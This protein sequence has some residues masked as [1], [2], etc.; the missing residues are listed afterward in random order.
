M[1]GLRLKAQE[2]DTERILPPPHL[3][4]WFPTIVALIICFGYILCGRGFAGLHIPSVPIYIGEV[5][6]IISFIYFFGDFFKY[7]VNRFQALQLLVF[8]GFVFLLVK[9]L[10]NEHHETISMLR[11]S[12][13]FYYMLF[14]FLFSNYRG[15]LVFAKIVE[16][17]SKY[18]LLFGLSLFAHALF[19]PFFSYFLVLGDDFYGLFFMPGCMVPPL[20]TLIIV[21]LTEKATSRKLTLMELFNIGILFSA[22]IMTQSRGAILGAL[23]ALGVYIVFLSKF[24]V[25]FLS[26]LLLGTFF[27]VVPIYFSLPTLHDFQERLFV[28]YERNVFDFLHSEDMLKAKFR[29]L[30]DPKGDEY[31]GATGEGRI[32]WWKAVI[33]DNKSSPETFLLGQGFG[34]NL[35][36]A[37]NYGKHTVRGAHNA[38]INIFGWTGLVGV[39]LYAIF[40]LTVFRFFF[41]ARRQLDANDHPDKI[42]ACNTAL[43]FLTAVLVTTMFDNS[44]SGPAMVIPLY[45]Y[46][47]SA[48]SVILSLR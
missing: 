43:V 5:L 33:E 10:I 28:N 2:F 4:L 11:D 15:S 32:K 20:A 8:I 42:L 23:V 18:H 14:L 31:K 21:I 22:I 27:I 46:L 24:R 1:N 13:T 26:L 45:V 44:L 16:Y 48:A 7:G 47:G 34:Q 41:F 37:I 19:E 30:V 25:R 39:V 36:E 17:L 35:G 40:F 38:W 9:D 6:L 3:R 12:A 29:A